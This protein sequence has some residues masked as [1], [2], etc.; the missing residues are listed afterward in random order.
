V[1]L[2]VGGVEGAAEVRFA[3]GTECHEPFGH[4]YGFALLFLS[5]I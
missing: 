1:R 2:N 5:A 4:W 3:H